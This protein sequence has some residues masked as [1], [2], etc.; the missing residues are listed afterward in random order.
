M[1]VHLNNSH[2]RAF[3]AKRLIRPFIN[4]KITKNILAPKLNQKINIKNDF[5]KS[6][7]HNFISRKVLVIIYLLDFSSAEGAKSLVDP[8]Y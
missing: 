2:F 5:Q 8:F 1:F 3:G 7:E 4:N 6:L